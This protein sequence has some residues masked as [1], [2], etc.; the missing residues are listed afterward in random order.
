MRVVRNNRKTQS[1]SQIIDLMSE[2]APLS[3][4]AIESELS[5]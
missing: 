4:L 3:D 2:D 1:S 5:V